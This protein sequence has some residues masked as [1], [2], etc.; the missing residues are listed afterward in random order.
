MIEKPHDYACDEP[1]DMPNR[2]EIYS[3]IIKFKSSYEGTLYFT[4]T[5]LY[6]SVA[7]QYR[8]NPQ[9]H[10]PRTEAI[11][12]GEIQIKVKTRISLTGFG[13]IS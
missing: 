9:K 5:A 2:E 7:G 8:T 12:N 1:G 10:R 11:R 4:K 3:N 6:V 13:V